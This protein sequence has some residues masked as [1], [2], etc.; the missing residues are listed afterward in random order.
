[1]THDVSDPLGNARHSFAPAGAQDLPNDRAPRAG[2]G[3]RGYHLSSLRDCRIVGAGAGHDSAGSFASF[4]GRAPCLSEANP[5]IV[6]IALLPKP[7]QG[8]KM[9]SP[10]REPWV[11]VHPMVRSPGRGDRIL[12]NVA[13]D[14]L[15]NAG[16]SFAPPGAQDLGATPAPRTDV[17]GYHLSPLPGLRTWPTSAALT[18]PLW[19]PRARNPK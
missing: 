1:M 4:K 18:V 7:R 10:R 5:L 3:A 13:S 14:P 16:H 2:A 17:R 8:R 12:T 6:G 9:D 19:V 11:S 15:A